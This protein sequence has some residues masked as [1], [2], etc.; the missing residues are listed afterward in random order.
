MAASSPRVDGLVQLS[1]FALSSVWRATAAGLSCCPR[2]GRTV[3]LGFHPQSCD[4][5][6]LAVRLPVQLIPIDARADACAAEEAAHVSLP[7]MASR[8]GDTQEF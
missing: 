6:G 7:H 3:L 8:T 4:A 5:G 2:Y 1:L